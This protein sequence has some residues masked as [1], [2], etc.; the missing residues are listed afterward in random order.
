VTSDDAVF[1]SG[2]HE[3]VVKSLG[4]AML[5]VVAVIFV[6]CS[7]GHADPRANLAGGPDRV[8]SLRIYL[9]GFSVNILTLL[10]LVL[11]TEW[12]TTRSLCS[13]ISCVSRSDGAA[14][15]GGQRHV[16]SFAVITTTVTPRQFYPHR[17]SPG[18]AGGL[19]RELA[20]RRRGVALICIAPQSVPDVASRLLTRFQAKI[21]AAR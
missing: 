8:R 19:F 4:F 10:A 1:I 9:V 15:G 7:T 6:F 21:R 13:R 20:L 2:L 18:Q 14:R 16:V 11:A 12:L 3:E 17:F 5:I